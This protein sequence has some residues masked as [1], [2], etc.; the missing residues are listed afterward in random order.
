MS[1]DSKV[2]TARERAHVVEICN[3]RKW[4]CSGCRAVFFG[5]HKNICPG[6]QR[7]GYWSGSVDPKAVEAAGGV[8]HSTVCDRLTAAIERDRA[9]TIEACARVA[10]EFKTTHPCVGN[11]ARDVAA[12]IRALDTRKAP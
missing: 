5:G 9:A 10:D 2:P 1:D 6:C 4:Q 12:R 7:E 11:D 8:P 3:V